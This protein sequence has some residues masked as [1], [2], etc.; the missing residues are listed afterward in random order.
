MSQNTIAMQFV[1]MY[2]LHV[3]W[4]EIWEGTGEMLFCGEKGLEFS[5]YKRKTNEVWDW[6]YVCF[7]VCH[8]AMGPVRSQTYRMHD[9]LKGYKFI[10]CHV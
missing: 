3:M 9:I 1:F 2:L 7:A 8:F 4:T 5:S 6:T 10:L